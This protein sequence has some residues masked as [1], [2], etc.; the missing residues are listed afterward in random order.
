MKLR[1]P[2]QARDA[3][4]AKGISITQWA[5]ANKYSPNLVYEVLGGRKKCVRGQAHEIAVKLGL[6]QG[7]ICNDPAN[8]L[9]P[10]KFVA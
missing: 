2:D 7:E 3:L 4:K 9:E 5:I 8:A 6:K 1:T 10:S